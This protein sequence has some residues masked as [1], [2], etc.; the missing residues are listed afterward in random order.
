MAKEKCVLHNI[1]L[2]KSGI[3]LSGGEICLIELVRNWSENVSFENIIYTPDNGRHVYEKFLLGLRVKFHEIGN[4]K[5]EKQFGVVLSHFYKTILSLFHVKI[6]DDNFD[7]VIISHS[8]FFPTV[9]FSYI[10]KARNPDA[11][12]LAFNHML[13]PN[14]FKGFKYQFSERMYKF[15]S[16]NNLYF[17]INQR[18]FFYLA[19]KS[20][21]MLITNSSYLPY[22]RRYKDDILVIHYSSDVAN[23][24]NQLSFI[25]LNRK[26]Y[27]ACFIG[28][29]HEQK[30]LFEILDII[31]KIIKMGVR[32][33]K[34]VVIGNHKNANG[35]KFIKALRSRKLDKNIFVVGEKS[36]LEKYQILNNSKLFIFPSYYESFGIVYLE[37]I[38]LGVPVLEYD[39]PIYQ[40]HK[41]GAIKI[42][43]LQNDVFAE[44]IIQMLNNKS[45]YQKI[46]EEGI[47]YSKEF[48]WNATAKLISNYFKN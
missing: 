39:L 3:G 43:F 1:E 15:P 47:N 14:P 8:D 6:F 24:R 23:Y 5:I 46:S 7:H 37:A 33:I 25:P 31:D 40:D 20:D 29:F 19:R 12:W 2:S 36:G 48:S 21:L 18:F 11:R 16:V 38:S 44:N 10:L 26:E 9:I 42:P 27:D 22:F 28:R 34:C 32:D 13:A 35:E 30:G 45:L 4:Y 41:Y 17:W